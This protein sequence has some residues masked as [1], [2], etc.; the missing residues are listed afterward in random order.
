R[1]RRRRRQQRRRE[2]DRRYR[3]PPHDLQNFASA[4]FSVLQLAQIGRAAAVAGATAGAA[5]APTRA[6]PGAAGVGAA[7]RHN[8]RGR[9][10]GGGRRIAERQ[11]E[12]QLQLL[13]DQP[14]VVAAR[15]QLG[16]QAH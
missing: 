14:A 13:L 3:L 4:S 7:A 16:D 9:G 6:A 5:P 10:G 11:L 8:R 2:N 12:A 1:A 15:V